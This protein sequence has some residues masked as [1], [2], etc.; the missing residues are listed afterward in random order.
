MQVYIKKPNLSRN[1]FDNKLQEWYLPFL[2]NN[3]KKNPSS[4]E[5]RRGIEHRIMSGF[6]VLY[7]ITRN[8]VDKSSFWTGFS[9]TK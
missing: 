3:C 6:C 9:V 5:R 7:S 4:Y 8:S 1:N 2:K